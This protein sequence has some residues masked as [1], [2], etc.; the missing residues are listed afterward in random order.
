MY[1]VMFSHIQLLGILAD[2]FVLSDLQYNE[3]MLKCDTY[4]AEVSDLQGEQRELSDCE[5]RLVMGQRLFWKEEEKF[6][7]WLRILKCF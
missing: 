4:V 3:L 2:D 6:G 7:N 5:A 1:F